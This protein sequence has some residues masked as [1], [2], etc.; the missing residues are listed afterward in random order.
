MTSLDPLLMNAFNDVNIAG[1]CLLTS[2]DCAER[3]GISREKW[4]F[5]LGGGRGEDT[6]ECITYPY[7]LFQ[8][9]LMRF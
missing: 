7:L 9:V 8:A 5:P 1:A 4:I 3:M 2:T 6:A